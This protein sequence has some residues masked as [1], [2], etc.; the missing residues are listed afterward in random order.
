[1]EKFGNYSV[2]SAYL[3]IE[4]E[5]YASSTTDNSGFW[6]TLWNLKIPPIV[7]NFLWRACMGCLPTRD[8]LRC[9]K[10]Q[11]S[12]VCVVCNVEYESILHILCPHASTCLAKIDTSIL[13]VDVHSLSGYYKFFNF[14]LKV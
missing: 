13:M 9:R 14:N 7:K 10:I 4:E 8:L 1:M 6:R 3:L 5:K 12:P 11:V 2:N